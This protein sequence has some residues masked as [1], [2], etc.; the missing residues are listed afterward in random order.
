MPNLQGERAG[1]DEAMK[2]YTYSDMDKLIGEYVI[3]KNGKR[4]REILRLHF[5]DGIT[6]REIAERLDMSETQIQRIVRKRGDE[7]LLMIQD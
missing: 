3:G 7:I 1:K 2:K 4:D 6:N 5:L